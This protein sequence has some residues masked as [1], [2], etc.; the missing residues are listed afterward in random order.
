M[1]AAVK[2]LIATV[3]T[4]AVV[5]TVTGC[6]SHSAASSTP[7]VTS[8]NTSATGYADIVGRC[9]DRWNRNLKRLGGA[10]Q[11][12][13]NIASYNAHVGLIAQTGACFVAV[14]RNGGAIL[15]AAR[16]GTSDYQFID[17]KGRT[18]KPSLLVPNA[19]FASDLKLTVR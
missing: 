19:D 18:I 5:S 10:L 15:F 4:A 17:L 13:P 16:R 2:T 12:V 14:S 6:G 11:K 7:P 9:A 1:S 3:L 8:G